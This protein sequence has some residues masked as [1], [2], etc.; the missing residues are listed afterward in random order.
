MVTSLIHG[1]TLE[2]TGAAP[3]HKPW[4]VDRLLRMA[5]DTGTGNKLPIRL[6]HTGCQH[7]KGDP[8]LL[9]GQ[10]LPANGTA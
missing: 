9:N 7:R 1:V 8:R 3:E 5:V 6:S 4:R 2:E 10:G